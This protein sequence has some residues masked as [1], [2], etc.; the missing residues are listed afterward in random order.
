MLI[1]TTLVL[2]IVIIFESASYFVFGSYS[3]ESF[4]LINYE[5]FGEEM[6]FEKNNKLPYLSKR[7]QTFICKWHSKY[8][9]IP[10][11]SKFHKQIE[12]KYQQLCQN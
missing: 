9:C 3:S 1:I 11:W 12:T 8:H 2:F 6:M 7:G 10:R 4:D 5:I